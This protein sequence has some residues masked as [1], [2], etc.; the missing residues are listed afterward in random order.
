MKIDLTGIDYN[1]KEYPY[2]NT[3]LWIKPSLASEETI[4]IK[5]RAIVI[6]GEERARIF[7]ECLTGWNV[8]GADDKPL[9]CTDEV[10]QQVFDFQL[11]LDMVGLVNFVISTAQAAGAEKAVLEKNYS[12]GPAGGATSPQCLARSAGDPSETDSPTSTAEA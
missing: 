10:K 7:K 2:K 12:S 4:M 8:I 11:K 3:K 1:A 5:D 9:P 6:S